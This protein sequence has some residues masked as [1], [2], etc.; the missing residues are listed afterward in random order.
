[1]ADMGFLPE[2]RRLLDR[3]RDERQTL[4][5][6]ATLDGDVGVLVRRYQR[7]PIRHEVSPPD[8]TGDGAQHVF[9]ATDAHQRVQLT[10]DIVERH[11]STIVFCRTKRGADRLSRQLT[12]AGVS[13]AAIHGDRSQS[14][15]ERAL[16]AF[17]SG[18][19]RALVATD[20]AARGIHVDG[21]GCVVHFDPPGDEKDY[22]HRSGRTAR[23]GS[24]GVVVSLVRAEH[25]DAVKSMQRRLGLPAGVHPADVPSLAGAAVASAPRQQQSRPARPQRAPRPERN[26]RHRRRAGSSRR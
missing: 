4:L 19:V 2:V 22:I 5:F 6:S 10:I 1:M 17:S 25:R 26:G 9:W 3:V 13:A 23:A 20:V 15:R 24:A 21:V 8:R 7:N 18:R 16:D 11:A 12:Q 14:Q